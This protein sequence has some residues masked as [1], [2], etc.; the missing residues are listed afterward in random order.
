M[1]RKQ[2]TTLFLFSLCHA[3]VWTQATADSLLFLDKIAACSAETS[4]SGRALSAA[5]TMLGK[6]YVHGC[7]DRNSNE[8]LVVNLSEL[9]CW[10]QVEYSVAIALT[11]DGQ[12]G[13]FKKTL[14]QLRYWGGE[15]SNYASRMHYFT[16]W[17]L[18]AEKM[19]VLQ[20][21]TQTLGGV[22]YNKKFNYIS[23]RPG[24]YPAIKDD[25]ILKGIQ[26]AERRINA[27]KWYY[28][29]KYKIKTVEKNL[30]PGDI[31]MLTSVKNGLDVAHQGFA[32]RGNDGRIHLLHASS[33]KKKVIITREPLPD[34]V[35]KQ[36]GQSG[37]M[38][39]RLK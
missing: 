21:L 29:P 5:H 23:Q 27:H 6:P 28:I 20:D 35:A 1:L 11:K 26:A 19:G 16:G 12:Y 3:V 31:I 24:K 36:R 13:T 18:Q 39:M 17:V 37:I 34:Y 8:Q 38:V 14:Q 9:D 15:I 22:A 2:I 32:V 7:L 10:T 30:Q 4:L 33:L 25:K